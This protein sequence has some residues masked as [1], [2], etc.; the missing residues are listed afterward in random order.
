LWR[1]PSGREYLSPAQHE[2]PPALPAGA[3]LEPPRPPQLDDAGPPDTDQLDLALHGL[4]FEDR[5]ADLRMPE[6]AAQP[7]PDPPDPNNGWP[8]PDF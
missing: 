1:S 2:P 6:Q 5:N 4:V 7:P 8:A 3:R